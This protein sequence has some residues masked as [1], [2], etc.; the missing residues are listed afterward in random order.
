MTAHGAFTKLHPFGI[1]C[2]C[3]N[4]GCSFDILLMACKMVSYM[5]QM[6]TSKGSSKNQTSCLF[7]KDTVLCPPLLP[8]ST[9]QSL[10]LPAVTQC[11]ITEF[12]ESVDTQNMMDERCLCR[13]QSKTHKTCDQ[14]KHKTLRAAHENSGYFGIVTI[15]QRDNCVV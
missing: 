5:S 11:E 10:V 13:G 9:V 7:H 2:L 6:G 4:W 15:T 14:T 8:A 12:I 3:C 1:I